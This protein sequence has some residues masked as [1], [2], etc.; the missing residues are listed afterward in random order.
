MPELF[1]RYRRRKLGYS[2]TLEAELAGTDQAKI[3][4]IEAGLVKPDDRLL[5]RLAEVLGVNPP[6]LLLRPVEVHEDATFVNS[7]ELVTS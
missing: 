3:S 7:N 2:Q 6:Y 1:A 4:R 5:A